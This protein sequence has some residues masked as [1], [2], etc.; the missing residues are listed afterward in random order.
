MDQ[1]GK[2]IDK[3]EIILEVRDLRTK[4]VSADGNTWLEP[5][6]NI[7]FKIKKSQR[8]AI[9]GESGC[10]KSVTALSILKLLDPEISRIS[11]EIL[12]EGKNILQMKKE[13]LQKIRG[14]NIA[15]IFQDPMTSLNP[16]KRDGE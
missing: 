2:K 5:V 15:M 16:D 6:R 12:I 9:V 11:G 10:G 14:S 8:I 4:F 3:R 1:S 7:S 13:E